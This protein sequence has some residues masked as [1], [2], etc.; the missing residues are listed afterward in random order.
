MIERQNLK[1][2][3]MSIVNA[4]ESKHKEHGGDVVSAP[5]HAQAKSGLVTRAKFLGPDD[6]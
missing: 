6:V 1:G 4:H 3:G 5:D 2:M